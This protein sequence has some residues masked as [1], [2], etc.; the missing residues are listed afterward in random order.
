MCMLL[1]RLDWALALQAY[2]DQATGYYCIQDICAW[3]GR[4][5][6]LGEGFKPQKGL[7]GIQALH[8]FGGKW[9]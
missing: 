9:V 3:E 6:G 2:Y 1:L 4:E 7:M 5:D 8:T